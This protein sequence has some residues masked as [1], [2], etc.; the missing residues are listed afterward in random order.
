MQRGRDPA[1]FDAMPLAAKHNR[2]SGHANSH[3][4]MHATSRL[5]ARTE[6]SLTVN[7]KREL[8]LLIVLWKAR[9][10]LLKKR[11]AAE[12]VV[13]ALI[14]AVINARRPR[15][16]C[17]YVCMCAWVWMREGA[18]GVRG[19]ADAYTIHE[20]RKASLPL[21]VGESRT[22]PNLAELRSV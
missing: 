17:V 18:S 13:L 14:D 1:S 12:E 19:W 7:S 5:I 8:A 10:A 20:A 2:P 9:L 22:W 3:T 6:A 4:C 21:F 15:R 11:A 16:I